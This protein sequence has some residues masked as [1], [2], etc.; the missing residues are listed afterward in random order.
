MTLFLKKWLFFG[1]SWKKLGKNILPSILSLIPNQPPPK[2]QPRAMA[3]PAGS[4]PAGRGYLPLEIHV[5]NTLTQAFYKL[6]ISTIHI[7]SSE[8]FL[9]ITNIF[10]IFLQS[11]KI[12]PAAAQFYLTNPYKTTQK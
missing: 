6:Y 4:Q 1:F 3:A 11:T 2:L 8:K 7:W 5:V 9:Q 10:E 12:S